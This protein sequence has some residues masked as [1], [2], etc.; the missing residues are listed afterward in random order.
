MTTE[1]KFARLSR[2]ERFFHLHEDGTLSS[3]RW[4]DIPAGSLVRLV[5]FER[6]IWLVQAGE[7]HTRIWPSWLRPWT[8]KDEAKRLAGFYCYGVIWWGETVM[9]LAGDF[10][11]GWDAAADA[12]RAGVASRG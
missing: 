4:V 10:C 1:A 7:Y 9:Q 6:G 11:I 5:A 3:E 12:L 8:L 2:K